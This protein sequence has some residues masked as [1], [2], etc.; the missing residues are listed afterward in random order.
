MIEAELKV[1]IPRI[2]VTE[3][4]RRHEVDIKTVSRRPSGKQGVRDLIEVS[5]EEQNLKGF[6]SDLRADPWV[7]SVDLELTDPHKLM[8]EVVT[9][10]CLACAALAGS[11]CHLMSANA[12]RDGTVEWK[13]ASSGRDKIRKLIAHLRKA[14]F[15]VELLRLSGIGEK[16]TLT[17]RQ[18][19]VLM[20]AFERGY[21]E[22]PRRV[23]LKDLAKVTGVSQATLS[24][25]L[26]KGQKKILVEYLDRK[27]GRA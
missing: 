23:K 21:F 4:P 27:R 17:N 26:R 24:E 9:Y 20:M 8:G 10:K 12:R 11:D 1:R 14:K 25:V 16:E 18:E 6:L 22:T 5:G 2:W 19:E 7:K 3:L 15:D 13:V